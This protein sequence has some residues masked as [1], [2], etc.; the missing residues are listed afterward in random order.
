MKFS[1]IIIRFFLFFSFIPA[2]AFSPEPDLIVG[3]WLSDDEHLIV[4]CYKKNNH[5]YGKIVWFKKYY[6]HLKHDPNAVPERKW[7]NT[8]VIGKF[9]FENGE[10]IDGEI[11]DL[12]S[13]KTF[14]GYI[15][16]HSRNRMHVKGFKYLRILG[17]SMGFTRYT[18]NELPPF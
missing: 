17:Q 7:M 2:F 5:Y 8:Q 15:V 11:Y 10:W 12:K 6:Y 4:Q 16:A 1:K 3:D 9:R 13:G 18:K 14:E